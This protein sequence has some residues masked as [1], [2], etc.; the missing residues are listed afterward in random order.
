MLAFLK[1]V[2]ASIKAALFAYPGGM[3]AVL[4]VAVALAARFGLHLT[5]NELTAAYAV[6]AALIGAFVHVALKAT[7]KAQARK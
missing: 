1:R 7:L 2:Y 3:A 6:A 5:V 4:G